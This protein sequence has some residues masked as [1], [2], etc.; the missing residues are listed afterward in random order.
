MTGRYLHVAEHEHT[1]R[2]PDVY[3]FGPP[4]SGGSVPTATCLA[5]G[6]VWECECSTVFV[7]VDVPVIRARGGY[8]AGGPA[9][10]PETRRQRRKRLGLRWWQR[11]AT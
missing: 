5:V 9:W 6:T 10:R 4:R 7:V 3:T 8:M 1:C 11:E 2:P